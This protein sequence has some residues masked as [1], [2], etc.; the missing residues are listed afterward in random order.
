[1]KN[2]C[3]TI[4]SSV[5]GRSVS[6][7][8][9]VPE[10]ENLPCLFLLHGYG[11]DHDQ[12]CN[13]SH[14]AQLAE[15]HGFVV[16][17]PACGDGFYEDTREDMPRFLGEE[18]VAYVRQILPVSDAREHTYIAGVSMGGFGAVLP[19]HCQTIIYNIL[20]SPGLGVSI[21]LTSL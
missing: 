18:L 10:G 21:R 12:W 20:Y 2:Y 19:L 15:K 8:F 16:V 9:I 5:L 4:E 17:A 7:R 3:E 14:I 6:V 13:K 11:G 1:M